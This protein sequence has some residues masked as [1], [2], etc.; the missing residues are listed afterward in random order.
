MED[1]QGMIDQT[2]TLAAPV[3]SQGARESKVLQNLE[4]LIEQTKHAQGRLGQL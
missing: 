1:L 3:Q 2:K 4:S